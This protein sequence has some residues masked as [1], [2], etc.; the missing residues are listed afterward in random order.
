VNQ[1]EEIRLNYFVLSRIYFGLYFG[2]RRTNFFVLCFRAKNLNSTMQ[3]IPLGKNATK[4]TCFCKGKR[5]KNEG[6]GS[7]RQ[8]MGIQLEELLAP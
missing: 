5:D 6:G 8:K 4:I 7:Q 1:T 3:W 2:K